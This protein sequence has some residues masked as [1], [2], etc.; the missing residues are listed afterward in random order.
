MAKLNKQ[1]TEPEVSRKKFEDELTEFRRIENDWRKKGVV[2][3]KTNFPVFHFIFIAHHIQPSTVAFAVEI[4]FTNYD[5]QPPSIVFINP[6]SGEPITIREMNNVSF[7]Q[8]I[9]QEIQFAGM[10]IPGAQA[11]KPQ[12]QQVNAILM[13]GLNERPFLCIPGVREYHDHPAHTN[14]PWLNYRT[15]GEGKLLFLLDQ[16][17]NHCIPYITGFNVNFTFNIKQF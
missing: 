1:V 16:L 17:Y 3:V 8:V 9:K 7:F 12:F 11:A 13:I 10:Q 4:D 15:K 5:V 2:C 6:F 14:N